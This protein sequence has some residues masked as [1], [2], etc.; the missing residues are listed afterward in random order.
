LFFDK[1]FKS[2]KKVRPNEKVRSTAL[3][4]KNLSA[5][6]N[7][8]TVQIKRSIGNPADLVIRNIND[9]DKPMMVLMYLHSLVDINQLGSQVIEPV[10]GYINT[11]K[12]G[13][14]PG[15]LQRLLKSS[16][17]MEYN[18]IH[19]AAE[20][21]L[22]GQTLIVLPDSEKITAVSIPGFVKRPIED[23]VTE[24]VIRGSREGFTETAADNLSL[25]RRWIKDPNLRVES[26]IIGERTKTNVYTLYLNDVANPD[27]V[28]ELRKRLEQIKIDGIVD[29]GYIS[30]LITDSRVTFFPLVQDTERP[31]KVAAAILEG[32]VAILVDKSPFALIVPATSNEFYQTP[33]DFSFNYWIG[34]FLRLIRF[35]GTATSIYL[36]ALYLAVVTVNPE[37]MPPYLVQLIASGRSHMPF[38]LVIELGITLLIFEIFRE[39]SVRLPGNINVIL[40]IGGG[41]VMGQGAIQAGMVGGVTVIVVVFTALASFS[42]ANPSKEQAWRLAR[43]FLLFAAG[44]FG[45]LGLA[46]AGLIILAHMGSLKS[47]GVSYLEPFAP[48]LT[49]DSVDAFGRLPWWASFRRPPTYRPQQEDRLGTTEGEDEA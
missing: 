4:R 23:S 15:I 32:R 22:N 43:Y 31:D 7:K 28:K 35:I 36:P 20:G 10:N 27:V 37:L 33:E 9:E 48:P 13:I 34:T 39:A 49:V 30:E 14:N 24:K 47:F 19:S 38:P 1:F 25:I 3:R 45:L 46:S 29:S 5:D 44:A 12:H 41:I 6:M 17:I 42:T 2:S 18:D 11:S 21:L 8:N 40:G 16:E 26:K